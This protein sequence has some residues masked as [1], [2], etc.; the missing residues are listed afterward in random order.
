MAFV[1]AFYLSLTLSPKSNLAEVSMLS[2]CNATISTVSRA[3]FFFPLLH[4]CLKTNSYFQATFK[5]VVILAK[6]EGHTENCVLLQDMHRDVVVCQQLKQKSCH[7]NPYLFR[8]STTR[9]LLKGYV[10]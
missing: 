2:G 7:Q 6:S 3:L 9:L 8:I 5:A 4:P 10:H 1:S